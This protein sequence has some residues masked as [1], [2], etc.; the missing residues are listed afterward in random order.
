MTVQEADV[1]AKAPLAIAKV[2]GKLAELKSQFKGLKE[3]LGEDCG[4][5]LHRKELVDRLHRAI[6]DILEIE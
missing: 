2:E 6:L 5:F 1:L 3:A 4:D